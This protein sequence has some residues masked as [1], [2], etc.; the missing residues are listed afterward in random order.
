MLSKEE[1]GG[2]VGKQN[3]FVTVID[4]NDNPLNGIVVGDIYGNTEAITGDGKPPGQTDLALWGNEMWI[5]VKRGP[6]QEYTS[7]I[8]RKLTSRK[9]EVSDLMAGGYCPGLSEERCLE[10]RELNHLCF[11][12]YSYNV[13]L[14]RQ[15]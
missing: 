2:C 4:A 5:I 7:E 1:N 12:H 10:E 15:W 9:P 8:T 6:D 3:I 14:Q 13:I 11:G